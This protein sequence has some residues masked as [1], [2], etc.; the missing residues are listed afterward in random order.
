LSLEPTYRIEQSP[1]EPLSWKQYEELVTTE[2][3]ALL[4]GKSSPSEREVQAFLERHPSMVP[5]AFGFVGGES[6][7]Y[8]RLCGV[9][10]QPPLPSYD[11]RVPDFM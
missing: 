11:H 7:H 8:P 5:G 9:I 3:V 1:E 2:W 4:N 10:A 6:G